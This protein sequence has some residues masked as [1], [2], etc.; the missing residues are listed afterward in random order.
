[1]AASCKEQ[2]NP[3]KHIPENVNIKRKAMR[4]LLLI[5]A[6]LFAVTVKSQTVV[7]FDNM[8]TSSTSYLTA[9]WWTP[10]ATA[11]WYNNASVSPTLSAVLYGSG[12]GTSGNEQ[13][14][15]SLSNVTGLDINRQYQLKFRLGSYTFTSSTATTR[16]VDVADVVDVQVSRNGGAFISELRVTGNTN[17]RWNYTATGVINHTANGSFTNS[18]APTGDVY[19]SPAGVTTTGPSTVYLTFPY[20]TSQIA[21]DLFCR[22]NSAGEEWWIDNIELLDI[23]PIS[24]PVELTYFIGEC[25]DGTNVLKWQTA[26]EHNSSHYTLQRSLSGDFLDAVT[27]ALTPAAGNSFELIN[28]VEIDNMYDRGINYYKLLQHDNDGQITEYGPIAIDNSDKIKKI[29]KIMNL[30][31]QEVNVENLTATGI[32]IELYD[33]G[34]MRRIYK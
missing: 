19:Q 21:L 8:E 28:Y 32:Y 22:V 6:T 14:W 17:A 3:K 26:S 20:G 16:G 24:L 23:T 12:T 27:V 30:R 1:M 5:F 15:Y 7:E 18:A 25:A 9:G 10:A 29:V 4:K 31:G 13:D 34:T 33:D 2:N 11:G